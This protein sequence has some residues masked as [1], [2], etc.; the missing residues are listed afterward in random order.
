MRAWVLG[1]GTWALGFAA[2]CSQQPQPDAYGNVEATEVVVSSEV[3]GQLTTF[4]VEEGQ[5]LAVGG[6]V[7]HGPALMGVLWLLVLRST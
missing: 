7:L 6:L 2:A 5:M 3:G 1:L 4:T